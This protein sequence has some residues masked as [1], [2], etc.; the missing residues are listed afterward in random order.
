MVLFQCYSNFIDI[1][2][3]NSGNPDQTPRSVA[4]DLDLHSLHTY[5]PQ[6][7]RKAYIF[8]KFTRR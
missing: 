3:A 6:T 5:V 1:L 8:F 2:Y 7:R 4:S